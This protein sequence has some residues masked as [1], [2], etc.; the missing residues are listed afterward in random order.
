MHRARWLLALPVLL[1]GGCFDSS[2]TLGR[3]CA[4]DADCG[5]DLRCEESLCGGQVHPDGPEVSLARPGDVSVDGPTSVEAIVSWTGMTLA[6]PSGSSTST[7]GARGYLELRVDG[8]SAVRVVDG[9]VT[10]ETR[11]VVPIDDAGLGIHTLELTSH[12]LDGQAFEGETARA[13]SRFWVHDGQ[14]AVRILEPADGTSYN[15]KFD[16][17]EMT[18]SVVNVALLAELGGTSGAEPSG[19]V[20][21]FVAPAFPLCNAFPCTEEDAVAT[22]G[23]GSTGGGASRD[24]AAALPNDDQKTEDGV[25]HVTAAIIGTDGELV[26]HDGEPIAHT[27]TLQFPPSTG[28]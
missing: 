3:V 1:A 23:S 7:P 27:I 4:S 16:P 19:R 5:D 9:E 21:L 13:A 28:G 20:A 2:F 14:P 11:V 18:L 10:G 22:Y 26:E 17:L 6:D 24:I 25:V 12:G 8:S 15:R